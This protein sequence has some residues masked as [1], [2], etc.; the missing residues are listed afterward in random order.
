MPKAALRG[1]LFYLAELCLIIARF[2]E[3]VV[4]HKNVFYSA[5]YANYAACLKGR[6]RLIPDKN[7]LVALRNDFHKMVDAGMFM[8][9]PPTFEYVIERLR[10][11]EKAINHWE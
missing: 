10:G 5:S 9:E 8:G 2:S 7:C 3:D 4:K 11:L 1:R 6:L